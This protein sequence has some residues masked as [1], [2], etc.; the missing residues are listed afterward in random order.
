[1]CVS[2]YTSTGARRGKRHL[3][4]LELKSQAP[5]NGDMGVDN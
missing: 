4:P 3:I 5:V 2:I 1:M